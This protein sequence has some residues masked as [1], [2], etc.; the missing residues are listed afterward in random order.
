MFTNDKAAKEME[1]IVKEAGPQG[2]RVSE[3]WK[4]LGEKGLDPGQ[5]QLRGQICFKARIKKVG[6]GDKAHYVHR[7]FV[8]KIREERGGESERFEY[9]LNGDGTVEVKATGLHLRFD[10]VTHVVIQ[11]RKPRAR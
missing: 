10:G 4:R 9:K 7:S 5:S 11:R 1:R 8:A 2:I 3:A 6:V